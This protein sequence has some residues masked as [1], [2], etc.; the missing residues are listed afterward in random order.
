MPV[1]YNTLLEAARTPGIGEGDEAWTRLQDSE[2]VRGPTWK[3]LRYF[4]G[5]ASKDTTET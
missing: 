2:E 3:P 5:L 4:L 1:Q